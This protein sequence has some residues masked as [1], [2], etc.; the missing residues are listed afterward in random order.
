[1]SCSAFNHCWL[2]LPI[3]GGSASATIRND[4]WMHIRPL[5]MHNT[6]YTH[7]MTPGWN[8]I[9]TETTLA[10][11]QKTYGAQTAGIKQI[12]RKSKTNIFNFCQLYTVSQKNCANLFFAPCLSNMNRFQWS[13]EGLSLNNP[14][15]KRCLKCPL[16][17]KYVL[18]LPWEIWS[19]RLSRQH[20]NCKLHLND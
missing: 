6:N 12:L 2:V 4:G 7:Y 16:H 18:A 19:V 20:N 14:L 8:N 3:T 9:A 17:P 5:A 1:V 13:L 11:K 10:L 15:T